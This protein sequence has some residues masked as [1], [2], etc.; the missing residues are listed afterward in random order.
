M[1]GLN[2]TIMK[3]KLITISAK[4]LLGIFILLAIAVW[5]FSMTGCSPAKKLEQ[6]KQRVM[7]DKKA[8][9]DVGNAFVNLHPCANDTAWKFIKGG[10][11][12]IPYP[13]IAFDSESF[14]SSLDSLQIAGADDY[15][16]GVEKAFVQGFAEARKQYESKKI[17][18]ARPD[19]LKGTILDKQKLGLLQ[20]QINVLN[21]QAGITAGQIIE[22]DRQLAEEKH[23]YKKLMWW[24][25]G[26]LITEGIGAGIYAY[27][28]FK[29][30]AGIVKKLI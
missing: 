5:I 27:T 26:I 17:A 13:V 9:T 8:F 6:A 20:D 4:R 2:Q 25:I 10:T 29:N 30:P 14:K 19:T 28:K 12:S 11:D 3:T 18:V 15:N 16:N 1:P 7:L 23:K 21:V 24:L 22:K